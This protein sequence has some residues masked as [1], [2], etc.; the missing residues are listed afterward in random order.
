[1]DKIKIAG[2]DIHL[3]T[4][5]EETLFA[6]LMVG[7]KGC[8]TATSGILPEIMVDIY[9]AWQKGKYEEA[10]QLQTS[11]LLILRTMF[12]LP[13][14]LGFKLAMEMRGFK[15]GP[16]KQPLSDAERFK[17]RNMKTRIE[18]IMKVILEKLEKDQKETA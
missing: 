6:C 4:G 7:G 2:E 15:M 8:M 3:L 1:M 18:R 13:F 9:E 11:I 10:R 16:P 12:A 17:Y 14:P 5:R